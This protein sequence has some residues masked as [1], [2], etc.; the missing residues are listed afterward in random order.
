M[1]WL[2][3][4]T[5]DDGSV[6][7]P[8]YTAGHLSVFPQHNELG[9]PILSA[10]MQAGP[11]YGLELVTRPYEYYEFL[12]LMDK[13][14]LVLSHLPQTSRTSVHI[15]VDVA[16]EP[17]TYVRNVLLWAHALEAILFRLSC[18]GGIH[19]G[20]REHE[21]TP[22]D[23]RYARPLSS[24]IAIDWEGTTKPLIVWNKLAKATTA[25]EFVA[26][27]GRL[28]LYWNA[29]LAHY[30]PHRLHMLNLA[31]VMRQGTLEWRLFDGLYEHLGSF[32]RTVYAVHRLA[33]EGE[34]DFSYVLGCDAAGPAVDHQWVSRLLDFDCEP[35]WGSNWQTACANK[36]LRSH[37]NDAP[38]L[39]AFAS[40]GVQ[41]INNKRIVDSGS[42]DFALFT[43]RDEL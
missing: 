32:A 43:R 12:P 7:G 42:S 14:A 33:S 31:S 23:H 1:P 2:E 29:G 13:A 17:W 27:W 39:P 15:H 22:N 6:R 4:T 5:H 3:F 24:P 26:A 16:G 8:T 40:R 41:T 25:S 34:P 28:D 30:C 19:R 20:S 36:L 21:G 37:Y 9:R 18:G 38:S 10:G 11:R 35:M